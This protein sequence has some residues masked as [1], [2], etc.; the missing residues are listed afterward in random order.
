MVAPA[1]ILERK[2]L[3]GDDVGG[4]TDR[5]HK[6]RAVFEDGSSNL[7]KAVGEKGLASD[8]LDVAPQDEVRLVQVIHSFDSAQQVHGPQ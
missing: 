7:T 1:L 4:G 8:A 3:L 5:S 2:H 6:Q